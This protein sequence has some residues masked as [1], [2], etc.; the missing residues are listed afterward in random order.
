MHL[1]KLQ[2]PTRRGF[3]E[4]S[5]TKTVEDTVKAEDDGSVTITGVEIRPTSAGRERYGMGTKDWQKFSCEE[6][7]LK[8]LFRYSGMRFNAQVSLIRVFMSNYC[9]SLSPSVSPSWLCKY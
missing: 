6:T 9:S 3:N 7:A 2:V 1:S 5:K 4:E 8:Q